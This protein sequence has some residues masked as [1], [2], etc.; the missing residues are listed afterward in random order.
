MLQSVSV[1]AVLQAF[2]EELHERVR[3]E[4]WGYSKN[5]AL[6]AKDL[7]RLQY[8]VKSEKCVLRTQ[9]HSFVRVSVQHVAIQVNLT[10]QRTSHCGS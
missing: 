3:R 4:L 10:T 9:T 8:Q 1:R 7:H 6:D 2:A 5:E